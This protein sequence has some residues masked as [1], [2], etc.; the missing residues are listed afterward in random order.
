MV[1]SLM[2]CGFMQ[3]S[4]AS[5]INPGVSNMSAEPHILNSSS[6]STIISFYLSGISN[7]NSGK[8]DIYDSGGA[9]VRTLNK[10]GLQ[11]GLNNVTWNGRDNK[12]KPVKE[13]SYIAVFSIKGKSS[14]QSSD[15]T[16]GSTPKAMILVDNTA[17]VTTRSLSGIPGRSGWYL[18]DVTVDLSASDSLSDVN[19]TRYRIDAGGWNDYTGNFSVGDGTHTLAFY[20]I[21]QAGNAEK[22]KNI[23]I[24]VDAVSPEI[25][26]ISPEDGEKPDANTTVNVTFTKPIDPDSV[27]NSTF[28][29]TDD[30]GQPVAS[31]V[32]YHDCVL[33]LTPKNPLTPGTDYTVVISGLITDMYGNPLK[34]GMNRTFEVADPEERPAVTST[35]PADGMENVPLKQTITVSFDRP[36]LPE[37]INGDTFIVTDE[38][39]DCVEGSIR[40]GTNAVFTPADELFYDTGYVA[41]ITMGALSAGGGSLEDN[42]SWSFRTESLNIDTGDDQTLYESDDNSADL[43]ADD[44]N[45]TAGDQTGLLQD[46]NDTAADTVDMSNNVEGSQ[47]AEGMANGFSMVSGNT[48]RLAPVNITPVQAAPKSSLL[49]ALLIVSTTLLRRILLRI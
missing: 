33:T 19:L 3:M 40:Y 25:L 1:I 20:S 39:G 17:P 45:V 15:I 14:G 4:Y 32:S 41:T 26:S 36:M 2:V 46:A 23:T 34:S 21:D 10:T 29:L 16:N 6:G 5:A 48:N 49:D 38:Y 8:L 30:S 28:E 22:E 35:D 13:G 7:D 37:S 12:G 18:G 42:Y 27:N 9:I 47:N 11:N 31:R 44:D 24:K 43:Q